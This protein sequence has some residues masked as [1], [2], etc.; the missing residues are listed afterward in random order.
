MPP[1]APFIKASMNQTR[2]SSLSAAVALS[3]LSLMPVSQAKDLQVLSP[4]SPEMLS[5]SPQLLDASFTA[6]DGDQKLA[7][8]QPDAA[9]PSDSPVK[10]G[11]VQSNSSQ[12]GEESLVARVLPHEHNQHSAATLYVRNIPVLT[13]LEPGSSPIYSDAVLSPAENAAAPAEDSEPQSKALRNGKTASSSSSISENE[14][15]PLWQATRVAATINELARQEPDAE[16]TAEWDADRYRYVIRQGD[17]EIAAVTP[18]SILPDT[19]KNWEEDALQATNRLRR[20]LSQDPPLRELGS[21]RE[22]APSRGRQSSVTAV[23]SASN[24]WASWYGL[25]FHGAQSANGEIFDSRAMT[26]AHLTLPFGT[27]VRVTNLDNGRSVIVRIND[28]GPY[29]PGRI[30]DVSEGAAYA[31]GMINSGVAPIRLEILQ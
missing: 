7:S 17:I 22:V 23:R 5:S 18:F 26:A 6:E 27:Q 3:A 11:V 21:L 12:E 1:E 24:G 30:L 4:S 8:P 25:G 2:W 15:D 31:L 10:V 16:I 28:R 29:I 14:D 9:S 13:F 20:L 19:T